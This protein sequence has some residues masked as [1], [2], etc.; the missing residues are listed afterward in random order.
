MLNTNQSI[1]QSINK[2]IHDNMH[3]LL[4]V[5]KKTSCEVFM[6]GKTIWPEIFLNYKFIVLADLAIKSC[7][8]I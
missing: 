7:I 8:T 2:F 5:K 1:N 3:I 4:F 6:K